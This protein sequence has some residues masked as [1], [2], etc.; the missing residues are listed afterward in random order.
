MKKTKKEITIYFNFQLHTARIM[1]K[2]KMNN[3][4]IIKLVFDIH[5][6]N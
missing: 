3:K 4:N 1:V 2:I 6:I 5:V